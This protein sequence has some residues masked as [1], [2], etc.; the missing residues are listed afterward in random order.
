MPQDAFAAF[1]NGFNAAI[2]SGFNFASTSRS[3]E[4]QA[5]VPPPRSQ[6]YRRATTKSAP[7]APKRPVLSYFEDMH[8]RCSGIR[9]KEAGAIR[10]ELALVPDINVDAPTY[11]HRRSSK[12][13]DD[14]GVLSAAEE[15]ES[16]YDFSDA[17]ARRSVSR[18]RKTL[19]SRL[20]G[21]NRTKWTLESELEEMRRLQR[22]SEASYEQLRLLQQS[23]K[24]ETQELKQKQRELEDQNVALQRKLK[25]AQAVSTKLS[26]THG[27]LKRNVD[28][29]Q[30]QGSQSPELLQKIAGGSLMS[31]VR[32][33]RRVEE[34]FSRPIMSLQETVSRLAAESQSTEQALGTLSARIEQ[35]DSVQLSQRSSVAETAKRLSRQLSDT[36]ASSSEDLV[37]VALL[38]SQVESSVRREGDVREQ[39]LAL[40]SQLSNARRAASE[41][42]AG[43]N[44]ELE[45]LRSSRLPH[46]RVGRTASNAA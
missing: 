16:D 39:L 18:S 11:K 15:G 44:T 45:Y 24:V 32:R 12:A 29:I 38:K 22:E 27:R 8:E 5:Q 14:T 23:L 26:S 2:A 1:A 7:A 9:P 4:P 46:V 30:Q 33:K 3:A 43:A 25:G 10:Y 35:E 34:S 19:R 37:A 13:T 17:D 40:R 6:S 20:T 21:L 28:Y 41:S 42:A 31:S 36:R